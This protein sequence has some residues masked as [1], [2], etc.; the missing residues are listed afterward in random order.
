MRILYIRALTALAFA[1]LVTASKAYPGKDAAS[2]EWPYYGNDRGAQRYSPLN[3]IN[4][5]N[6]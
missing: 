6:L 5:G 3:Q 4:R 2:V 1:F